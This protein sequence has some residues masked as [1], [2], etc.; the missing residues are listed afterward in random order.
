MNVAQPETTS[1]PHRLG[2]YQFSLR[3]LLLFVFAVSFALSYAVMAVREWRQRKQL[4]YRAELEKV[5]RE[6]EIEKWVNSLAIPSEA[7]FLDLRSMRRTCKARVEAMERHGTKEFVPARDLAEAARH[8]YPDSASRK[9]PPKEDGTGWSSMM[10][11]SIEWNAVLN[12]ET[13]AQ[14]IVLAFEYNYNSALGPYFKEHPEEF[15]NRIRPSL[16][17]LLKSYEPRLRLAACKALLA[18]GNRSEEV[19]RTLQEITT[20]EDW[21]NWIGMSWSEDSADLMKKYGWTPPPFASRPPLQFPAYED[22]RKRSASPAETLPAGV[23]ARIGATRF[24]PG[25]YVRSMAFSPD[26]KRLAT[27]GF[28]G[29]QLWDS[30]TGNRTACF[31]GVD[32]WGE[33]ALAFSPDGKHLAVAMGRVDTGVGPQGA[34]RVWDLAQGRIAWTS[35]TLPSEIPAIAYSPGS[36]LLASAGNDV[37]AL[38]RGH[39]TANGRPSRR[40]AVRWRRKQVRRLFAG[41]QIRRRPNVAPIGHA[42]MG[43]CHAEETPGHGTVAPQFGFRTNGLPRPRGPLR[44]FGGQQVHRGEMR[45]T[46]SWHLGCHQRTVASKH[47]YRLGSMGGCFC[48]GQQWQ[49]LPLLGLLAA[50]SPA[51]HRRSG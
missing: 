11:G 46:W 2:R 40:Q 31:A 44:V 41:R 51:R 6:A 45:G 50:R 35:E 34:I 12:A 9:L 47:P 37:P 42:R 5:Q 24:Q 17:R 30:E 18:S 36:D 14:E 22:S 43:G 4:D 48:A 23:L 20:A 27:V 7:M 38:A 39:R 29:L 21:W 25:G 3:S 1:P 16:F 15:N 19:R 33:T 49:V 13:T 28:N 8:G 32:S 26:G 10:D